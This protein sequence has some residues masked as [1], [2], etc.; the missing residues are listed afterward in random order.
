MLYKYQIIL[1]ILYIINFLSKLKRFM[2]HNK[3]SVKK[4]ISLQI[5]SKE[6][7]LNCNFH[8]TN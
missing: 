2:D 6:K 1:E 8:T 3:Y 4:Q 5:N 7:I